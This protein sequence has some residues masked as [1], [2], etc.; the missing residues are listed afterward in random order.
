MMW[1]QPFFQE[2]YELADADKRPTDNMELAVDLPQEEEFALANM[3]P[4]TYYNFWFLP[5]YQQEYADKYLLFNDISE[6]ELKVFED[7]FTK[8]IKISLVEYAGYSVS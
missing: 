2:E 5:K 6:A 3:M 7:T 4:Y 1:G 8:L